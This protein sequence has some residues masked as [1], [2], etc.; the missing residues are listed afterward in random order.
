MRICLLDTIGLSYDGSTLDKK[1]LGGSESAVI[2]MSRYLAELGIDVTVFCKCEEEGVYRGVTYK[3]LDKV[4]GNTEEFDVIVSSRNCVPFIP[5]QLAQEVIQTM[6]FNPSDYKDL[7]SRSNYKIVWMHD[8]FCVGDLWL[9]KLLVEGYVN[10]IFTLTDWHS[11]FAS[12][13]VPQFRDIKQDARR[14]DVIKN[15]IY[16]TR[17]GVFNH[18]GEVDI[19]KKDRNKF[20]YNA[21][22][23]KGMEPLLEKIW[24]KVREHIPEATLTIIG[25]YYRFPWNNGPDSFEQRWLNL[26]ERYD[27]KDGVHFTGVISQKEIAEELA[28]A[29]FFIYPNDYRETFG[30][31]TLE[32]IQY[33]VPVITTD[34]GALEEV[35]DETVCY[36]MP[37][38]IVHDE[39]QI[40][41]FVNLVIKAYEDT[42]LWEQKA[43]R[44][45]AFKEWIGWDKVAYLWKQ[46]IYRKLGFFNFI[47][48]EKKAREIQSNLLRLFNRR[49]INQEDKYLDYSLD[50][51]KRKIL[52]VSPLYNAENTIEIYI[53]SIAA[54]LYQ[55]Y[56]AYVI[57]D[58]SSDGTVEK[59]E[60]VLKQFPEYIQKKF[61]LIKNKERFGSALGNQVNFLL[62]CA[63]REN[64]EETIIALLDGDDWLYN[65]PDICSLI[66]H[67]YEIG[68]RITYGSFYSLIDDINLIAQPYPKKVH[69]KRSYRSYRF[70]W[71]VPYTHLRTFLLGE[72]KKVNL[73]NLKDKEGNY[74]KA[75]GDISLLYEL[76]EKVDNP[77]KSIRP[78]YDILYVYNDR[79]P[80]CDYKVNSEEQTMNAED[81]LH[82]DKSISHKAREKDKASIEVVKK[83]NE[84]RVDVWVDDFD[85]LMLSPRIAKVVELVERNF[86]DNRENLRVLDL[87]SWTGGIANLLYIR[88]YSNITCVDISKEVVEVGKNAY[89]Y[90]NWVQSDVENYVPDGLYDIILTCEILEHIENPIGFL[91]K[92]T[93]NL[94]NTGKIIFSMPDENH[95][96]DDDNPEHISSMNESDFNTLTKD[97][98]K[99]CIKT[100]YYSCDFYMGTIAKKEKILIALPTAK[101]VDTMTFKS[102]FDLDKYDNM[103]LDIQ[104][105]Y[106][107]RVDQVRNLM[108]DFLLLNDYSYMLCV[109]SDMVLPKR[110]LLDLYDRDKGIVCGAYLKK[111][112]NNKTL[113]MYGG[114]VVDST[115]HTDYNWFM[116]KYGELLTINTCGFGCVLIKRE[117]LEAMKYPWFEYHCTRDFKDSLSEDADFCLKAKS[118]GY[119]IYLD[120]KVKCEHV[121]SFSVKL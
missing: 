31:S 58:C 65:N 53:H 89:P 115:G 103:E 34:N 69:E 73:N 117:V 18:L 70:P 94:K 62:E 110:A 85:S 59:Y 76:F 2:Y 36:K 43:Y 9:E 16:Q 38:E 107:Y 6:G 102:I 7:V 97:V 29:S 46:H 60:N 87:G 119:S 32:A 81:I 63:K 78:I 20:I 24:F 90:F 72:F 3:N 95:V 108:V 41:R 35:A 50:E 116:S 1:G 33:N 25:G 51:K 27:G 86:P 75:G 112:L 84:E 109:D 47:E 26:K 28:T 54:Q 104:F 48:H 21:S 114:D 39:N 120:T 55:N 82:K 83:R 45:N 5:E 42:R 77:E 106:G 79:N 30:I 121:G 100:N 92:M 118:L 52:F 56:E 74:Y 57:D 99:L 19:R 49:H 11:H 105:F 101:Y 61:H 23:T 15:K 96:Y 17:N 67:E 10:E 8:L 37:Y 93:R 98:N 40:N 71:N 14:Y 113:E 80:L 22:I 111:D 91:H 66:N 13:L 44:C 88:G 4:N 68:A 64:G 12:S